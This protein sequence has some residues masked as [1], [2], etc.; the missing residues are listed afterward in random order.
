MNYGDCVKVV[1]NRL[2]KLFFWV[3]HVCV[4]QEEQLVVSVFSEPW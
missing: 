2:D 1:M 3:T 4:R